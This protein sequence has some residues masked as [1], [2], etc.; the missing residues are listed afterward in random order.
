MKHIIK[1]MILVLMML[2]LS[3]C[4][5]QPVLAAEEVENVHV[6]IPTELHIEFNDDGTVGY[7]DF[8]VKNQSLVPITL[9]SVNVT[10]YNDWKLLPEGSEI[11]VNQKRMIFSQENQ[12][13]KAGLN[14]TH[15]SIAENEEKK[16]D[17]RIKRGAWTIDETSEKALELEFE[18]AIGKKQFNLELKDHKTI[19]AYN[20][21]SVVLPILSRYGYKFLG[22]TDEA[23][24]LYTD[25]YVMPI[26]DKTLSPK[27]VA[28]IPYAIYSETDHSLMFYN[29]ADTIK[30]GDVYNGRTVTAIYT[31][32]ENAQYTKGTDVPWYQ[33]RGNIERVIVQDEIRPKTLSYWFYMFQYCSEI[34]VANINTIRTEKMNYAFYAVGQRASKVIITGMDDWDT[35]KVS[36]MEAMFDFLGYNTAVQIDLGDLSKWNVSN[37]T[38]MFC[39]FRYVGQQK[40]TSLTMGD[41]GGWNVGKVTDMT[42]TI[43]ELAPNAAWFQDLSNWNV[44]N[45]TKN[46]SFASNVESKIKSPKWVN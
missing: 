16:L 22:W 29:T 27:W 13:L 5:S 9:C 37:V 12:C 38:T 2:F 4:G 33:Y 15:V 25:K 1:W 34:N 43:A 21:E 8:V 42:C 26:G 39:M 32:I 31:G 30:V 11:G 7:S 24:N 23:G 6:T 41:I 44:S 14:S 3:S 45:V 10:E 46:Y 18:Y 40:C 36:T 19:S 20:G 35:S 28:T 17:F